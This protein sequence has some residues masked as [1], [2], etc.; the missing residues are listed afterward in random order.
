M[1]ALV[2]ILARALS[3]A[4]C[5]FRAEGWMLGLDSWCYQI[6]SSSSFFR[7]N[8][9]LVF[10]CQRAHRT[11]EP[12]TIALPKEHLC[13]TCTMR[14]TK[15]KRHRKEAWK[16]ARST[17]HS[18]YQAVQRSPE[19]SKGTSASAG[20]DFRLFAIGV[21]CV[22][23]HKAAITRRPI[24]H[25]QHNAGTTPGACSRGVGERACSIPHFLHHV[26]VTLV[27]AVSISGA[28][29]FEFAPTWRCDADKLL[30]DERCPLTKQATWI[31]DMTM[32]WD[33]QTE[34]GREYVC[35]CGR[36]RLMICESKH[37]ESRPL[38]RREDP[39]RI[40]WAL[41]AKWPSLQYLAHVGKPFGKTNASKRAGDSHE[42]RSSITSHQECFCVD[43]VPQYSY[44][45]K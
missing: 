41:Q 2:R 20:V 27:T 3:P 43:T 26:V 36:Q 15:R 1:S 8:P 7:P 24:Q 18:I 40:S 11:I 28:G 37:K 19:Q 4:A 29:R 13:Y 39:R 9:S 22:E 38:T 14:N 32:T 42:E 35:T 44:A 34:A 31:H 16:Q 10:W 5:L 33:D 23:E 30:S 45:L 17:F 21:C 6:S 12:R 25:R